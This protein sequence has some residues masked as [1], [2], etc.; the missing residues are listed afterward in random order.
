[1]K[2]FNPL[3]NVVKSNFQFKTPA[4]FLTGEER[5]NV[6]A[7][8]IHFYERIWTEKYNDEILYCSECGKAK[9]MTSKFIYV[10]KDIYFNAPQK[11]RC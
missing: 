8:V 3:W 2:H 1:M 6:H 10:Y 9:K 7:V 11:C 5:L 4:A